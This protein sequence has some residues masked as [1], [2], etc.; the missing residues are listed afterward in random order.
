MN[1]KI[2]RK[3][4]ACFVRYICDEINV[5][6]ISSKFRVELKKA[7]TVPAQKKAVK[8]IYQKV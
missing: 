8:T 7:Y 3:N 6:I 4:S 1:A 2:L 5:S